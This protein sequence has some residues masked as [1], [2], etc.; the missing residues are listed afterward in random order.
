MTKAVS[1]KAF[2]SKVSYTTKQPKTEL[3]QTNIIIP[4]TDKTWKAND[5]KANFEEYNQLTPDVFTMSEVD[6][7]EPLRNQIQGKRLL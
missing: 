7:Y 4:T 1:Q 5:E 6:C 3:A 2:R